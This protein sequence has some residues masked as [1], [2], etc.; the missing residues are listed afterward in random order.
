MTIAG[1]DLKKGSE[2][3]FSGC[4][5]SCDIEFAYNALEKKKSITMFCPIVE[6]KQLLGIWLMAKLI[7][8]GKLN[9]IKHFEKILGA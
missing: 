5:Y 1:E 9:K 3:W 2:L 8:N 7:E 4:G 6:G